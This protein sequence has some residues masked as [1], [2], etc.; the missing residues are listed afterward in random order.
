MSPHRTSD[1]VIVLGNHAPGCVAG[2]RSLG[3]RG[4][5]STIAS[6]DS[7]IPAF[8]SRYCT[9]RVVTPDPFGDLSNYSDT[10]L[11][12]ARRPD[13]RTL[14][15]F[16]EP[17]VYVLSKHRAEFSEHVATLWPELATLRRA[18]DRVELI[19]AAVDADV[20]VPRTQLLSDV[21]EWDREQ[22]VKARY[23]MLCD[24]YAADLS[25]DEVVEMGKTRYLQPGR[26]PD[27][28]SLREVMSHTPIVQEYVP[29][30][31]YTFRALYDRG[32]PVITSQKRLVRG[33]KYPRGPSVYH[34]SVSDPELEAVGRALLDHLV[35]HGVAS[36]GFMEDR[37]TG[38]F[39]LLEINPRFWASL[40]LDIHAGLDYPY[41]YWRLAGEEPITGSPEADT[42][43]SSHYLFGELS[44]LNSVLREDYP[45][46]ERP[47]PLATVTD[48][49]SSTIDQPNFDLLSADDPRPFLRGGWNALREH[50]RVGSVTPSPIGR[51][52]TNRSEGTPGSPRTG[53]RV[54]GVDRG[55]QD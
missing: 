7:T 50:V 34:E 9:E 30:T 1:S 22:V 45:L 44:H 55:G 51:P 48:I 49:V 41:Y 36:V 46:V 2:T 54:S 33:Q 37:R 53:S 47:S 18:Q 12:L 10:L 8:A 27:R 42:G 21:D 38:E 16:R 13:V 35:W 3:R 11:R 6:E 31:E 4:V 14:V 25:S 17:D 23:S 15:P 40:P 20:P 19:D 43:T 39:K 32:E 5:P 24:E 26:E 52:D 28:D 29:G